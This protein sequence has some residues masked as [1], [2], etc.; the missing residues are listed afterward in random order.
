MN[1]LVASFMLWN[2]TVFAIVLAF[3]GLDAWAKKSRKVDFI[4][5][6][7][8]KSIV[9]LIF[10]PISPFLYI[11]FKEYKEKHDSYLRYLASGFKI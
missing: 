2:L 1:D 10:I 11:F 4:T 9:L 8:I 5:N 6:V 3:N 7:F